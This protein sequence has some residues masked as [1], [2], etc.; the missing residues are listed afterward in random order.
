MLQSGGFCHVSAGPD[1]IV[2]KKK[3]CAGAYYAGV[4]SSGIYI[5]NVKSNSSLFVCA[6]LKCVEENVRAIGSDEL[7]TAGFGGGLSFVNR[8][9]ELNA[10]PAKDEQLKERDRAQAYGRPEKISRE[11]RD[12]AFP[13]A[14][15]LFGMGGGLSVTLLGWK[16]FYG[17]RRG[18]GA[19]LVAAGVLLGFG[20]LGLWWLAGFA[21]IWG[22]SL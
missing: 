15:L 10:L 20:G 9:F 21:W 11:L 2:T 7:Q 4:R 1:C 12:L 5:V 18:L 8:A 16:H 22:R 13:F 19:A 3:T 6:L 14:A 17:Q